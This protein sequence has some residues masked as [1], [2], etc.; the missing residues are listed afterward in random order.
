MDLR[1]LRPEDI[2]VVDPEV[3]GGKPVFRGTRVPVQ[4]LLDH[5]VAGRT[6]D[7]FL[8]G[9]P[10]VKRELAEGF[11]LVASDLVTAQRARGSYWTR[12]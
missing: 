1:A 10:S 3:L 12:M 9:F 2:Y 7:E 5:L 6:L 8:Q 4:H 11:L